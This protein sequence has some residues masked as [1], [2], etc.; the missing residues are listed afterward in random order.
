MTPIVI[1]DD[2]FLSSEYYQPKEKRVKERTIKEVCEKIV[3][4]RNYFMNG[5]HTREGLVKVNLDKS[6]KLVGLSRKSLDDY[7]KIVNKA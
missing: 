3:L 7:Y 6:A 5:Y 1:E 2:N 4:W